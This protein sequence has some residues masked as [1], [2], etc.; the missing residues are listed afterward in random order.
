MHELRSMVVVEDPMP[1]DFWQVAVRVSSCV[2]ITMLSQA[3]E[4]LEPVR[5]LTG[6]ARAPGTT[7]T[8]HRA[9]RTEERRVFIVR[10]EV[11]F[12]EKK[13]GGLL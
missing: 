10:E 13:K 4:K 9:R 3:E 2:S 11:G 7:A 5:V 6:A 1:P 12:C 8:A